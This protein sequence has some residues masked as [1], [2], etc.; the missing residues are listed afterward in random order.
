MF[1]EEGEEGTWRGAD[2][3][4]HDAH[5]TDTKNALFG[6]NPDPW[7]FFHNCVYSLVSST[8]VLREA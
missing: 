7:H 8:E 5:T 2:T 3:Q 1:K 4:T 6:F